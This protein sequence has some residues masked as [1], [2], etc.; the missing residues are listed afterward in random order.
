M[1]Q[2]HNLYPDSKEL[3]SPLHTY[4][5][6]LGMMYAIEHYDMQIVMDNFSVST[7]LQRKGIFNAGYNELNDVMA[8][9]IVEQTS[10]YRFPGKLNSNQR[11]FITNM[12]MFPRLHF[13]YQ[14]ISD[15]FCWP[16]YHPIQSVS[17]R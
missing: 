1:L 10:G 12:V 4:N 11:K 14:S 16:K 17:R 13:F 9:S 5:L 8:R 7:S 15:P 2:S 6:V 3:S